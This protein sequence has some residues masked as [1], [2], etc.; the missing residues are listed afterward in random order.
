MTAPCP[1]PAAAGELSDTQDALAAALGD[2]CD[3]RA[4]LLRSPI[5]AEEFVSRWWAPL[6]ALGVLA[7]AT[8]EG[9]GGVAEI[10]VTAAV[11]GRYGFPGPLVATVL[12]GQVLHDQRRQP[13]LDGLALSALGQGAVVPE[14][15]LPEAVVFFDIDGDEVRVG[16]T[17]PAPD[18]GGGPAAAVVLKRTLAARSSARALALADVAAASYLTG[19]GTQLLEGAAS[20]AKDRRQFG[21]PVGAFQ[22]LKHLMADMFVRSELARSAVYAA[23]VTLDDPEVGSVVRAVA[24]AKVTGGEA[25]LGNAKTCIQVHGGMGYTWEIDAHLML[26]RAYVL[27]SSFGTRDDWADALAD[28]VAADL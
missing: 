28:L 8:P 20:Y 10:A 21:R 9:G 26:K 12:A 14:A 1:V 27:E 5:H 11:L 22:A 16:V 15:G 18:I 4:N 23:G 24:G 19:A 2:F 6:G 7:L 25:A 17:E 13:V 3:D